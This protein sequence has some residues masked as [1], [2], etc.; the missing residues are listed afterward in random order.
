[1]LHK[2]FCNIVSGPGMAHSSHLFQMGQFRKGEVKFFSQGHKAIW[3]P[4]ADC[5][6]GQLSPG[7]VL[8]SSGAV[9]GVGGLGRG[10]AL[11]WPRL[12]TG[13]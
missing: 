8:N 10:H 5:S 6:R 3:M 4:T 7:F 2:S 9:L 11:S 13:I 1:M 12:L